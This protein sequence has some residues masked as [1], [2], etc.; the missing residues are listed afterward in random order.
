LG[1]NHIWLKLDQFRRIFANA[2]GIG[3]APASV[4]PDVAASGPA[5]SLQALQERGIFRLRFRII[6]SEIQEDADAPHPARLL[7]ERRE[8][9]STSFSAMQQCGSDLR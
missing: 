3:G 4:D 7:R 1:Q 5:Q 6:R 8:R 9:H 2:V